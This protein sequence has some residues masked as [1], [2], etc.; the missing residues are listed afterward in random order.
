MQNIYRPGTVAAPPPVP[1]GCDPGDLV[2]SSGQDGRKKGAAQEQRTL[3]TDR[4]DALR[5]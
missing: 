4:A 1:A 3:Q 2:L 5:V